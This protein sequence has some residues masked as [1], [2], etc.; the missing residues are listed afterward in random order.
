MTEA[1]KA[2]EASRDILEDLCDTVKDN[3][4]KPGAD[5]LC[6][7]EAFEFCAE[8]TCIE[9]ETVTNQSEIPHIPCK[10]S[11]VVRYNMITGEI[12]R[13]ASAKVR[14]L[15][16]YECAR[17]L[18]I[19]SFHSGANHLL[20]DRAAELLLTDEQGLAFYPA[21]EDADRKDPYPYTTCANTLFFESREG[22]VGLK[23]ESIS[24]IWL[25]AKFQNT[26]QIIGALHPQPRYGFQ[27]KLFPSMPFVRMKQWPIENNS[28]KIEW[29]RNTP[30]WIQDCEPAI[31][32]FENSLEFQQRCWDAKSKG[33]EEDLIKEAIELDNFAKRLS[34][35]DGQ[36]TGF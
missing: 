19:V 8:V 16:K 11:P 14:Q 15:S 7:K 3:T 29:I 12:R 13:Q 4:K 18:I 9:T 25:V 1:E 32:Y 23:R 5:F 27:Y 21:V 20:G 2:E 28:L 10:G 31:Q 17:L 36:I 6:K 22:V 24:A 34:L 30:D 26:K 33:E 35:H